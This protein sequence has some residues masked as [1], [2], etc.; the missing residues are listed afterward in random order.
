LSYVF[1][2][3]VAYQQPMATQNERSPLW[4]RYSIPVPY[5]VTKLTTGGYVRELEHD[6]D[7]ANIEV[8]YEGGHEHTVTDAEAA[9]LTAA[10]YA[11]C[12]VHLA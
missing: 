3:P 9:L 2:P 12:L 4:S 10:G 5:T 7:R 6:A 8:V 11:S 1:T